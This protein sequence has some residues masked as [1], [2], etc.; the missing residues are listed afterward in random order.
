[1]RAASGS[2]GPVSAGTSDDSSLSFRDEESSKS[3]AH[4]LCACVAEP[5]K[6]FCSDECRNTPVPTAC[7]LPR[8]LSSMNLFH[9]LNE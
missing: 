3:C 9:E 1:M 4:P 8:I 5:G 6:E 7:P 2:L